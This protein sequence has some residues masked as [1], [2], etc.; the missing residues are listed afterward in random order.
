VQDN[1]T[2]FGLFLTLVGACLL[3]FYGLPKK[4]IGNVILYGDM[5]MKFDD[6]DV[7]DTPETEWGPK[8][9]SFQRRAKVLNSAGFAL[10]AVGTL[11]QMVAIICKA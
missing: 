11:L 7:P 5:A 9:A 6:K 1:L 8:F 3:F 10:V 2:L 4:K